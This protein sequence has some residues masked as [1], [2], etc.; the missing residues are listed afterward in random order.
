MIVNSAA[1][2]FAG[3]GE[4]SIGQRV[5]AARLLGIGD[6]QTHPSDVVSAGTALQGCRSIL[7]GERPGV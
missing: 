4:D 6:N 2:Y 5:Y 1:R 7:S 3:A